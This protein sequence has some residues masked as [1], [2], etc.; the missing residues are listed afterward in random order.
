MTEPASAP[1]PNAEQFK[2]F[3]EALRRAIPPAAQPAPFTLRHP[4]PGSCHCL[5]GAHP[6]FPGTCS[7]HAEPGFTGV[8]NS[9]TGSARSVPLC[10]NCHDIR[11]GLAPQRD[12]VLEAVTDTCTCHCRA[13]H[14]DRPGVCEAASEDG[15]TID[16][17]PACRECEEAGRG[18]RT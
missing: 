5:C 16:G 13:N 7:G 8:V 14:P 6:E 9:P 10:R 11:M 18:Q 15:V 3:A 2:A 12:A 4:G 1:A 17:K